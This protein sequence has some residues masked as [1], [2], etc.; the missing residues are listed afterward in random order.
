VIK[1]CE[2]GASVREIC[3]AADKK[4]LEETGRT[5]KKEKELKKGGLAVKSVTN[6][7]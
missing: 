1:R 3:I 2:P 4:I 6:L 5:F 7:V